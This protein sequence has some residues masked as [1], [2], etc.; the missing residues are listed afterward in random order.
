MARSAVRRLADAAPASAI[1]RDALEG[2]ERVGIGPPYTVAVAGDPAAR[3]ELL[4][5]LAGER[6]FD[7]ARSDPPRVE[8]T[9]RRGPVTVLRMRRRG[10]SVEQRKLGPTAGGARTEPDVPIHASG[11]ASGPASGHASGP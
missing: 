5:L 4:N 10:G 7:A 9:L 1:A 6:L 3:S 8:M 2:I 11:H